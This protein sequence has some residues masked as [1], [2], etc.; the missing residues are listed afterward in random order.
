MTLHE[1]QEW[2]ERARRALALRLGEGPADEPG[3]AHRR[4]EVL[5]CAGGACVSCGN[6]AVVQAFTD[7]VAKAGLADFVKVVQ[8]GCVGCC[9]L[10]VVVVV[11]PDDVLYRQVTAAGARTIV[12]KHLLRDEIVEELL[13][14]TPDGRTC[15]SPAEMPF[16]NKQLKIVL[17]NS[18]LIDPQ[19]LAEY[20][21]RDGYQALGKALFEMEPGQVI[22]EVIASGLRGR[23]G[24]GFPTGRKWAVLAAADDPVKY[25]IC[26]GD[27][28]DPGAFM[29]RSVLES[30]PHRVLE[31]MAIAGYATGAHKGVLYV[32]AEYPLAIRRLQVAIDQAREQGLLAGLVDG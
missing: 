20:V 18:G 7:G 31:G 1:L 13:Y 4:R 24:G 14:R 17:E 2:R 26:N 23:G 5:V 19:S 30:D 21:G 15:R 22:Q 25:I 6:A 10:G 28:G 12:E 16:F 3:Q 27:E 11:R 29:D 32:R 9:D 8:T